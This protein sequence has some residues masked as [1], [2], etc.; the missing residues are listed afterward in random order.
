MIA[1]ATRNRGDRVIA[2]DG[3]TRV[4]SGIRA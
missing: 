4:G 3:P 2:R 1:T